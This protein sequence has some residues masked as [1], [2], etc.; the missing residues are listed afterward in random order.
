MI[1]KWKHFRGQVELL[2]IEGPYTG[3]EDKQ[4][5]TTLLNWM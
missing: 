3:M 2:L 5:V 4:K 1:A